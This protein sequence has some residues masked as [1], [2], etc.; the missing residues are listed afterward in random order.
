[1]QARVSDFMLDQYEVTVGRFRKFVEAWAQGYRPSAGAGKHGHINNGTG[2][3]TPGGTSEL[4]WQKSYEGAMPTAKASWDTKLACHATDSTWTSAEGGNESKP[5]NCVSWR[6]AYA[7]CIW[8]GGFL[9]SEAELHYAASGGTQQRYYPWSNP[10]NA[11]TVDSTYAVH[12]GAPLE[13]VGSKPNGAG[14]WG[15]LDLGGSLWEWVLD[16][17]VDPYESPCIDCFALADPASKVRLGGG[18]PGPPGVLRA[19]WR[20]DNGP[21]E[22]IERNGIRCARRP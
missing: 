8:D 4:G 17:W 5:I 6:D 20:D 14:R 19:G 9:P 13:N 18:Y 16:D 1:M 7:F 21:D 11:T 3:K 15:H 10:P 12:N 22:Q 2:L